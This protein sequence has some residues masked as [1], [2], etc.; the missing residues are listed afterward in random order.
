MIQNPIAIAL[1][2]VI[3]AVSIIVT[4]FSRRFTRT[5]ADF[6]VAGRTIGAA[7][8]AFAMSG[9]YMSAASFLGVAGL[10][11]L[12]GYDGVWYATGFFGGYILLLLFLASPIRRFGAYTIAD[13]VAGRFHSRRLRLVALVGTLLV[14]IFYIVPQ[15]VGAGDIL[16]VLLGWDYTM[17]V[18]I[19]GVLITIY[20]VVGGMKATT[21]NQMIQCWL[22]WIAM[23]VTVVLALSRFGFSYNALFTQVSDYTYPGRWLDFRNSFSLVLGLV[24]G[25]AGL[26]HVLIR[27][28][29][30]PSGKAARWTTV[31][32]LFI[33]GTFYMMTP[34]AGFSARALL[35][36][37]AGKNT[38]LPLLAGV[39]GGEPLLG[40][41]VAGAFAAIL[42]TVAGLVI[43][44]T[45]AIAH[46]FYVSLINPDASEE[47]RVHIAKA[48]AAVVGAFSIFAG[49]MFRGYNVAFQ[50]SRYARAKQSSNSISATDIPQHILCIQTGRPDT[51]RH[52]RLHA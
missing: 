18:V 36:D 2:L 51:A 47:K 21:Y 32:T 40:V 41:V 29:T 52:G 33:I 34:I 48:S 5:T 11:W 16:G 44:S 12:Y 3:V 23:F 43:A 22:L 30:N 4:I 35:G 27:Y 26:P 49:I 9:D 39:V 46:D 10:V 14:S 37:A 7:Q 19:A 8:N 17:A 31:G 20:V 45:G 25:T 50:P 24:L 38:A 6:Y 28:Y 42:S 1:V 15:M 13:F